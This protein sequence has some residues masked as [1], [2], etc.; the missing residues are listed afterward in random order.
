MARGGGSTPN[1]AECENKRGE[2]LLLRENQKLREENAALRRR[3]EAGR[4]GGV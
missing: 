2:E 4:Q 3:M 1:E